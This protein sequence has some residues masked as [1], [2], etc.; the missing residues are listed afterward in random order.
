M[1]WL[2]QGW[3]ATTTHGDPLPTLPASSMLL[4]LTYI[5]HIYNSGRLP[6][7]VGREGE[8][9]SLA[10]W[11]PTICGLNSVSQPESTG[12]QTDNKMSS[13]AGEWI[14]GEDYPALG[15]VPQNM[16]KDNPSLSHPA[17]ATC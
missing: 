6:I 15:Y 13:G 16:S 4:A 8:T 7:R 9:Q 10:P 17:H 14:I 12:H 3:K 5:T 1:P 11:L 2:L